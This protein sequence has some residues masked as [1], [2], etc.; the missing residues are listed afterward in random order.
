MNAS[1]RKSRIKA[2]I[3]ISSIL[4]VS[5]LSAQDF[6]GAPSPEVFEK[7]SYSPYA[8]RNF[9]DNVYWGDTHLHTTLSF[10]AGATA[11]K[12]I[13]SLSSEAGGG[14]APGR[15]TRDDDLT[16]RRRANH[17][18]IQGAGPLGIAEEEDDEQGDGKQ[19][20]G[21]RLPSESGCAKGCAQGG[22]DEGPAF[23]CDHRRNRT[24]GSI[25][26]CDA[27]IPSGL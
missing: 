18:V 23:G 5:A 26:R 16:V 7:P 3:I 19:D 21:R 10:D 12:L 22:K 27:G 25:L 14:G 6:G 20:E 8:N 11:D 9:P 15:G 24:S 17:V 1:H 2:L 4:S 13:V